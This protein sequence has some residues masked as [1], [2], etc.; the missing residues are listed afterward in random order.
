MASHHAA[1]VRK[2]TGSPRR[3]TYT[4]RVSDLD[5]LTRLSGDAPRDDRT[6]GGD[7]AR[8]GGRRRT[9]R[10][11]IIA[12][13]L[14]LVPIVAVT[15]YGIYLGHLVTTNVQQ[16]NLLP[17]LTPEELAGKP[18]Q[19]VPTG[20]G[21]TPVAGK[22]SNFLFI[23][24]D[25]GPDRSGARSDV[26]MLVH[27]PEDRHNV[28]FIHFP[29]DLYV[30]IPGHGKDKI[31]ASFAYGGA[32]L[33]VETL[34]NLTGAHVDHVA[35]IGFEGFKNMT[36]AVGG[37]DVYVAESSHQDKYTFT[38]GT[39]MHMTGEMALE[40]VRSR[41]ELSEGDI[42]RGQRQQEFLKALMLKVVAGDTLTNPV[43]LA[44]LVD[45]A[46]KNLTVDQSLNIG[47]TQQLALSLRN[48]RSYDV[49]F[50]TAPFTGF[51]TT[52]AGASIDVVD[53]PRMTAMGQAVA[54][55]RID[56]WQP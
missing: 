19:P 42:S 43:K 8:W 13:V 36:D 45:A 23:G 24:S 54:E 3:R 44:G 14:L 11:L 34:Q 40:F 29:R 33:L 53:V 17:A 1:T 39:T 22:G 10:V 50:I 7:D 20:P 9:K 12:L 49:R 37:V 31:N 16:E 51:S 46:T 5:D 47:E 26:I 15:G 4:D 38:A 2:P 18:G 21:A 32:P 25:A 56:L 6:T 35:K 52:S 55:D 28:T 30:D 27:I 48:V 41:Y